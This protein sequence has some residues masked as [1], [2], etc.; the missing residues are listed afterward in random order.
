[1]TPKSTNATINI[2]KI[3]EEN[4]KGRYYLEVIDIYQQPQLARNSDVLATPTLLKTK[5]EPAKKIIGDFSNQERVLIGLNLQSKS[6]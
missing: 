2:K 3:L 5:P 4:L 1:M 6:C